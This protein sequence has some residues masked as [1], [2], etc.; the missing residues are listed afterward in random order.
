MEQ[1]DRMST[2]SSEQSQDSRD[3]LAYQEKIA[4]KAEVAHLVDRLNYLEEAIKKDSTEDELRR[5]RQHGRRDIQQKEYEDTDTEP[6][7]QQPTYHSFGAHPKRKSRELNEWDN[8]NQKCEDWKEK[9]NRMEGEIHN[10][11]TKIRDPGVKT[12]TPKST[13]EVRPDEDPHSPW[14][15]LSNKGAMHLS[16]EGLI[17][18]SYKTEEPKQDNS[19]L[20]K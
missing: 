2:Y 12:S 7:I 18:Q 6:S 3:R 9:I 13:P 19:K 14:H 16:L 20:R 15:Q 8:I 4:S 17:T 1:E 10:L 5:L 11:T